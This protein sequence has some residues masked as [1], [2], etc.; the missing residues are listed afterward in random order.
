MTSA[1]RGYSLTMRSL[2]SLLQEATQAGAGEH[3]FGLAQAVHLLVERS[4]AGVEVVE[5][6]V[7]ALVEVRV[8]VHEL[9]QLVQCGGNSCS[10]DTLSCS[11]PA[12]SSLLLVMARTLS[13]IEA[14]ESLMNASYAFCA[15]VSAL[16]ASA[17]IVFVSEMICSNMP[18]TPPDPDDFLYSLKPGGGGGP[19]GCLPPALC[20]ACTKALS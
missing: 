14:F 12:F 11:A 19:A 17:S 20:S 13:S 16:T 15:S 2:R 1:Y 9:L 5:R 10:V 3:G 8:L 7:A 4:L 6:E 18:I